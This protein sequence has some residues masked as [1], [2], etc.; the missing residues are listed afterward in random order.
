MVNSI[1]ESSRS[2]YLTHRIADMYVK[3]STLYIMGNAAGIT[4]MIALKD[5]DVDEAQRT[6]VA[7]CREAS[8]GILQMVR[9]YKMAMIQQMQEHNDKLRNEIELLEITA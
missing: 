1:L 8:A 2:S 4:K 3:V 5:E 6:L 7:S 9:E